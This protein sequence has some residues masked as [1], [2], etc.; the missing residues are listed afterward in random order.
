MFTPDFFLIKYS[1][2]DNHVIFN[3]KVVPR[4]SKSEIVGEMNGA[5]KVRIASPPVDG[6]ANAEL[7]KLLAITFAVSK[8]EVEILSGETSKTK[9]IRIINST[10]EKVAAVLQAKN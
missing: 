9:Q 4:A 7:I 6:A 2:K 5:L 8:S 10:S 1:E 3:V